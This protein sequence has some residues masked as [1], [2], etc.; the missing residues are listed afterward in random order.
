MEAMDG[1]TIT[2]DQESALYAHLQ[3]CTENDGLRYQLLAQ[4]VGR[5]A[6]GVAEMWEATIVHELLDCMNSESAA[7]QNSAGAE[8]PPLALYR[9]ALQAG[10]G[11]DNPRLQAW[12]DTIEDPDALFATPTATPLACGYSAF[13]AARIIEFEQHIDKHGTA[14]AVTAYMRQWA[15]D[16]LATRLLGASNPHPR[17]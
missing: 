2:R 3:A 17:G 8:S 1:P 13:V 16:H 5:A 9:A 7:R 11:G 10:H 12:L 4:K 15:D 14:P 6:D